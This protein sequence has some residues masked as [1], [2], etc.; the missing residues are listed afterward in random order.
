MRYRLISA[1]LAGI[2]TTA[3][4]TTPG[5]LRAQPV[6]APCDVTGIEHIVAIGDVHG[7]YDRLTQI[8]RAAGLADDQLHWSG[9]KTHLVQAGDIL[10]RGPDSRK[11]EDLLRRLTDEA[12]AAGGQVHMLLGNHE[13]MRML[14]DMR[15]T[16][17]GEYQAFVTPDSE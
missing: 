13:V 5:V 2:V 6:S 14:G 15:Y 9:A 16:T 10:D 3:L 8:L 12:A 17:P 4:L 11:A 7:A 1:A